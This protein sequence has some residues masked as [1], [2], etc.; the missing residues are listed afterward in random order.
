[1]LTSI[2]LNTDPTRNIFCCRW[3]PTF[4]KLSVSHYPQ[5][6]KWGFWQDVLSNILWRLVVVLV[7]LPFNSLWCKSYMTFSLIYPGLIPGWLVFCYTGCLLAL[8]SRAFTKLMLSRHLRS[9]CYCKLYCRW[10]SASRAFKLILMEFLA[11]NFLNLLV[12]RY[13]SLVGVVQ[14]P[15]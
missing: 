14:H 9:F 6:I 5:R 4:W 11:Q 12:L 7:F 8:L 3:F 2:R 15:S 13:L 1:M 10:V